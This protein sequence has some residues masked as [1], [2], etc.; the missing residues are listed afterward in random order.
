MF[1]WNHGDDAGSQL[2]FPT[3]C[4]DHDINSSGQQSRTIQIHVA[5]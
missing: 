2:S 3:V 5:K 4:P 1:L